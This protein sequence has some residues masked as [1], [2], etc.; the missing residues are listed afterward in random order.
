MA[1]DVDAAHDAH[2]SHGSTAV[3]K[4]RP[5]PWGWIPFSLIV[6]LILTFLLTPVIA[7]QGTANN[8]MEM[9]I[10]APQTTAEKEVLSAVETALKDRFRALVA[11]NPKLL[12]KSF[13]RYGVGDALNEEQLQYKSLSIQ[14][15]MAGLKGEPQV[16]VQPYK[17]DVNGNQ[18]QVIFSYD[19]VIGEQRAQSGHVW[20]LLKTKDGWKV[21]GNG[22]FADSATTSKVVAAAKA[23]LTSLKF[24]HTQD[25][26]GP[27]ENSNDPFAQITVKTIRN[28]K[29][30][31]G[32]WEVMNVTLYG[33]RG[34]SPVAFADQAD[35]ARVMVRNAQ[36]NEKYMM[37]VARIPNGNGIMAAAKWS[38]YG[39]VSEK[40][41]LG[42]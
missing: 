15:K 32:T 17:I 7:Y 21:V 14:A 2:D 12:E 23:F 20:D 19:V 42:Q 40:D 25:L 29:G 35:V 1:H 3:Q 33:Q 22:S 11:Q 5:S 6:T 13:G 39:M 10:A 4:D 27:W 9:E 8:V 16:K 31:G 26:Q 36:T 41:L 28:L 37:V 30:M 34:Q 18:A 38:V 24:G